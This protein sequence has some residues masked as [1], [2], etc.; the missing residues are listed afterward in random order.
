MFWFGLIVGGCSGAMV[1]AIFSAGKKKGEQVMECS[2]CP[3]LGKL[4]QCR[5]ELKGLEDALEKER[6]SNRALGG[7]VNSQVHKIEWYK[8]RLHN[9]TKQI[10][11]NF[12][13]QNVA[14]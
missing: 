6:R 10:G 3:W 13:N 11:E 1:L 12:F 7:V 2:D 14:R 8:T 9:A 5:K 4:E